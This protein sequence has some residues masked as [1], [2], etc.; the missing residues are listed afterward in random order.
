MLCRYRGS[1]RKPR[2]TVAPRSG[3]GAQRQ[4]QRDK[5]GCCCI[6][7]RAAAAVALGKDGCRGR[8]RV[9]RPLAAAFGPQ[10]RKRGATHS[11]V[12]SLRLWSRGRNQRVDALKSLACDEVRDSGVHAARVSTGCFLARRVLGPHFRVRVARL[13]SRAIIDACRVSL[14]SSR[15]VTRA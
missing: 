13:C 4:R 11:G 8:S 12:P 3:A 15:G 1:L 6:G 14:H 9:G 7:R 2:R 5:S 10:V